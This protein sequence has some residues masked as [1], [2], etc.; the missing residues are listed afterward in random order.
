MLLF[1]A[2]EST[3]LYWCWGNFSLT[4]VGFQSGTPREKFTVVNL[5]IM[6]SIV[7]IFIFI[8]DLYIYKKP[9][10]VYGN[11]NGMI[12]KTMYVPFEIYTISCDFLEVSWNTRFF[13]LADYGYEDEFWKYSK[14]KWTRHKN[15]KMIPI[16]WNRAQDG[17]IFAFSR[18]VRRFEF[19]KIFRIDVD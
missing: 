2:R 19:W 13:R 11:Q 12:I 1:A 8:F 14:F 7:C 17:H 18:R 4:Y 15:A 3:M 9:C 10:C 16:T 6:T 5:S